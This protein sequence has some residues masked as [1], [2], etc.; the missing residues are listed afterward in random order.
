MIFP[1][2]S[3]DRLGSIIGLQWVFCEDRIHWASHCWLAD[4][5]TMGGRL[6][7]HTYHSMW[8]FPPIWTPQKALGW[9]VV[10]SRGKPEASCHSL[11]AKTWTVILLRQDTSVHAVVGQVLKCQWWVC[12]C[13]VCTICCTCNHLYIKVRMNFLMSECL[14]RSLLPLPPNS[15]VHSAC[16]CFSSSCHREEVQSKLSVLCLLVQHNWS[17][18][19]FF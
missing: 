8:W 17:H 3:V 14:L 9:Q 7:F 10:C 5:D 13:M 18:H 15:F 11:A 2:N 1:Q 12:V 4:Y 16:H 19:L 6:W